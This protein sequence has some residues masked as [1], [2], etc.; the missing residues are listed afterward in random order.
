M[1]RPTPERL[2]LIRSFVLQAEPSPLPSPLVPCSHEFLL[3]E[4]HES[5]ELAEFVI[6]LLAE[7][8]AVA[9]TLEERNAE[10]ENLL[11]QWASVVDA[12][13]IA[14]R[15]EDADGSIMTHDLCTALRGEK[16]LADLFTGG[17]S[18]IGAARW[19]DPEPPGIFG[20]AAALLDRDVGR[21]KP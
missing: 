4:A 8:D 19:D 11:R 5:E 13:G 7:V 21:V 3:G 9:S 14:P 12:S 18:A 2:S 10:I 1:S 6:A 20:E 16:Q 17:S 15:V